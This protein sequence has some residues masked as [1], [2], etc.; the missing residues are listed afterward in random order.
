MPKQVHRIEQIFAFI[1]VDDDGVEA[2][3]TFPNPATNLQ[4]PM[5]GANDHRIVS[6]LWPYVQQWANDNNS[7]VELAIFE[8][9]V[10]KQ[11][12]TPQSPAM[13]S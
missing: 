11:V 2:I 13:S 6:L 12:I 10:D 3:P 1:V 8:K 5:I 9:R 4:M 7:I